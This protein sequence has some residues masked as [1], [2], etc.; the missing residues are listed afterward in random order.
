M[1]LFI[2]P[3]YEN[4]GQANALSIHIVVLAESNDNCINKLLYI[5]QEASCVDTYA[6]HSRHEWRPG[7]MS[8]F[9][10][11]HYLLTGIHPVTVKCQ[12]CAVLRGRSSQS[13]IHQVQ[14]QVRDPAC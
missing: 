2:L 6:C 10:K 1:C 11:S 14:G 8:N 12:V 13:P 9:H 4:S 7:G 5:C 3:Q